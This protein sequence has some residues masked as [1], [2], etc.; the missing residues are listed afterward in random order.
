[1]RWSAAV[2]LTLVVAALACGGGKKDETTST[3]PPPAP[4]TAPPP[5]PTPPPPPPEPP[6]PPPLTF[7]DAKFLCCDNATV[8]GVL[9]NYLD[10]LD[11]LAAGASGAGELTA[12]RGYSKKCE[13]T[14][15]AEDKRTCTN[16]A[17]L[18]DEM[19]KSKTAA[20]DKVGELGMRVMEI[21]KRHKGSGHQTVAVGHCDKND[22]YWLQRTDGPPK[23]PF[24]APNNDC[25]VFIKLE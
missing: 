5:A 24:D 15:A 2:A 13:D 22:G 21:V 14:L 20:H 7:A 4:T 19:R 3:A 16:I 18:T 12:L 6:K 9:D 10:T 11:R 23:S 25:G 8:A 17:N 1:M